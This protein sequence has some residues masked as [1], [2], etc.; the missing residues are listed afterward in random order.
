[1]GGAHP[2]LR[3]R[4]AYGRHHHRAQLLRRLVYEQASA[5][6]AAP[7]HRAAI[8]PGLVEDRLQGALEEGC[9]GVSV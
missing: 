4:G 3:E 9:I 5:L 2:Q 6:G 1:M 7:E 8:G